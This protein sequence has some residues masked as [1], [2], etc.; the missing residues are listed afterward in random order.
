[1]D[2]N[3]R[4]GKYTVAFLDILGFKDMVK[5]IPLEELVKKYEYVVG[6]VTD[7]FNYNYLVSEGLKSRSIFP[8]HP[9]GKPYCTK[10][11]FSDSIILFQNGDT[12]E[13]CLKLLLHAWKITQIF[14]V[15][16]FPIRGA[17][18]HGEIYINNIQK[19]FVG[20]ALTAA[21]SLEQSQDWI[22]VSIDN[23]VLE[24]YPDLAKLLKNQDS[25]FYHVFFEYD[26]PLKDNTVKRMH[27]LNWRWNMVVEKGTR[28]LFPLNK[29]PKVT[30][31]QENSIRYAKKFVSRKSM[32]LYGEV[33]VEFA[34][35]WVGE[36]EPPFKHGDEL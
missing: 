16:G 31:K 6:Q 32:Y 8:N 22:G 30:R 11:I 18:T 3:I 26:V 19:I 1:M 10:Y 5:E 21:H 2:E 36:S 4:I 15:M 20:K 14:L 29:D 24:A 35:L 34:T 27:T 33:P 17:I 25:I 23:T 7:I 9:I 12:S 28:S 13:C